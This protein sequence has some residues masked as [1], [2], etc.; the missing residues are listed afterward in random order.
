M[1]LVD[2]NFHRVPAGRE[3]AEALAGAWYPVLSGSADSRIEQMA[4]RR[5]LAEAIYELMSGPEERRTMA[6]VRDRVFHKDGM[7]SGEVGLGRASIELNVTDARSSR[8]FR[9]WAAACACKSD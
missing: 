5:I 4:A 7:A 6:D 1:Q 8:A 9:D 3:N 2:L